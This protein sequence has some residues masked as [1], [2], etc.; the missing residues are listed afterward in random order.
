M[1]NMSTTLSSRQQAAASRP[2]SATNWPKWLREPLLH[3]IVL[4]GLLFAADY[5]IV[6]NAD[7]THTIVITEEID[8]ESEDLFEA[9]RGREPNKEEMTALQRVWLDNEI[10]YRE[11]LAMQLDKGD[12]AIRER[13]IFKALSVIDTNLKQPQADEAALRAWFEQ[14]REKYDEPPRFDFQEAV[15]AGENS[16]AAIREFVDRLNNGTPGDAEAGLRVFK[17]RPRANLEQTYGAE[18]ANA[19][20]SAPAG[21]W[22]A[23]PTNQGWR[24]IRLDAAASSKPAVFEA[25]RGVVQQDWTDA[26]MAELRTAA[27]RELGKKYQVKIEQV[28]VE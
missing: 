27:V 23:L 12:D 9:A 19:L 7:D 17:G 15:L 4:G 10:L 21:A 26:K 13:V 3:F 16:E 20:E 11:G 25:Y 1:K 2:K 14:H 8:N 28:M 24:A 6:G 18:F 5:A 22:R